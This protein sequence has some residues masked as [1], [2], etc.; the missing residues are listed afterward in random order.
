MSSAGRAL[1]RSSLSRRDGSKLRR[2]IGK[3]RHDFVRETTQALAR[4]AAAHDHV[5]DAVSTQGFEFAHTLVWRADQAVRLRFLGRMTIGQDMRTSGTV[6]PARYR[7]NA[8]MEL[9]ITFEGC[10]FG[11]LVNSD[12]HVARKS[13]VHRIEGAPTSCAFGLEQ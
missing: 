4:T 7:Q 12:I 9:A 10:I 2:F 3:G 8:F 1:Q 5:V 11:G 6:R 13:D